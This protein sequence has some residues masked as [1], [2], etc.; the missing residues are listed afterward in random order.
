MEDKLLV[1][2]LLAAATSLPVSIPPQKKRLM[3]EM[4]GKYQYKALA[5]VS[6]PRKEVISYSPP[7]L[8]PF[9]LEP[10]EPRMTSASLKVQEGQTDPSIAKAEPD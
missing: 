7:Q 6:K 4:V 5:S 8:T 9:Q 1:V 10:T 2:R 3:R